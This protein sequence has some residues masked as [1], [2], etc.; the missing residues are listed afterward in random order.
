MTSI[1][2]TWFIGGIGVGT[3]LTVAVVCFVMAAQMF[4]RERRARN[5]EDR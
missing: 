5:A 3:F 2:F 1:D 4:I